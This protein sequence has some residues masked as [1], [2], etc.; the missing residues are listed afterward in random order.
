MR[1]TVDNLTVKEFEK[2]LSKL[3]KKY[4]HLQNDLDRAL[5]VL[6]K[7]P[8]NPNRSFKIS[9]LKSPTKFSVYKLKKFRSIDF[10]NKGSQSG[11][12]L[13]YA[14]NENENKIILI[15]I[16]HKIRQKNENKNRILKYFS[17]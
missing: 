1:A 11:F 13:I 14:Y 16:Y 8:N 9:N 10:I 4:V 7:E 12:R 3:K 6:T 15:E 2:D 5:K 17:I